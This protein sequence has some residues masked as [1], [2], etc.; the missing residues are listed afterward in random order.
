[1]AERSL[2]PTAAQRRF[3]VELLAAEMDDD[4]PVRVADPSRRETMEQLADDGLLVCVD[5]CAIALTERGRL[6]GA[7][8]LRPR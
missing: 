2:T 5:A 6:R 3:L 4:G 8:L 7:A 1:M